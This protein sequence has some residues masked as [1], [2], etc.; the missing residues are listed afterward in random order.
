M[1]AVKSEEPVRDS[2]ALT[3]AAILAQLE[4]LNVAGKLHS[5]FTLFHCTEVYQDTATTSSSAPAAAAAAPAPV[6]AP[7]APAPAPAA[8]APAPAA[9]TP[10]PAGVCYAGPSTAGQYYVDRECFLLLITA[11]GLT[12]GFRK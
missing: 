4:R 5:Y 3:L 6:P 12:S 2:S 8:P 10:A 7:A 1:T 11:F 9:P